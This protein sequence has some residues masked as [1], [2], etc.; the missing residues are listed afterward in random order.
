MIVDKK[1]IKQLRKYNSRITPELESILI[2]R[3]GEDP[4]PYQ[5]SEQDLME[6]TRKIISRYRTPVGRLELLY[7]L[8]ILEAQL[9]A[10]RLK[11]MNEVNMNKLD[12]DSF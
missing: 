10:V 8:D 9:A 3:L 7:G 4:E 12:S 1:Y 2:D 6:Q 5:Y 11:I